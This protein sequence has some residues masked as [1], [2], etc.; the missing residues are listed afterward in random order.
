MYAPCHAESIADQV[1]AII[2]MEALVTDLQA[3]TSH[4]NDARA[5]TVILLA[6]AAEAHEQMTGAH[7]LRVQLLSEKLAREL[8][9]DEPSAMAI[10]QAAI[11]H[12][13]GKIRVPERILLSPARLDGSEWT[14]MKQHPTLG[15]SILDGSKRPVI[16]AAATIAF[17]F[18]EGHCR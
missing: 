8:G 12:D 10:G 9:H 1:T 14:I 4:L 2:H 5:D 7:L 3:A 17:T 6:A 15:H 13:I 11:L 18:S 16:A